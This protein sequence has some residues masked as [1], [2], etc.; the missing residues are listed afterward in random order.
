M[1]F[2]LTDKLILVTGSSRGIGAGIAQRL[3]HEGAKVIVTYSANEAQ[4]QKVI[5]G[6]PGQ[7]HMCLALNVTDENSVESVFAKISE[8]GPLYGLVNNAGI[9]RDQLLLRMKSDDL[10]RKSVV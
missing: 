1:N 3:A 2:A 5:E 4:A 6:L 8:A 10:D 9:T 7:G